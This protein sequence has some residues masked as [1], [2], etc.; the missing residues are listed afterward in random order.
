MFAVNKYINIYEIMLTPSKVSLALVDDDFLGEL[1]SC[2]FLHTIQSKSYHFR[3]VQGTRSWCA[4]T[5]KN[6]KMVMRLCSSLCIK[7]QNTHCTP[8]VQVTCSLKSIFGG[9]PKYY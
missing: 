8:N 1:K 9:I 2:V 6:I 3:I 5:D 7:C 4:E